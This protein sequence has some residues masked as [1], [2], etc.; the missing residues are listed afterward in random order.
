MQK[1][2][3]KVIEKFIFENKALSF[4]RGKQA[5]SPDVQ[6]TFL[7]SRISY[8]Y[9]QKKKNLRTFGLKV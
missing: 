5:L 9:R 3:S 7:L 8:Y 1:I 6:I 2:R 4:C